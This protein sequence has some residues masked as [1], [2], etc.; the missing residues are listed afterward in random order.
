LGE[1]QLALE[2]ASYLL[3]KSQLAPIK[4]PMPTIASKLSLS[5]PRPM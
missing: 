2:Q 3:A 5:D 4:K 1:L